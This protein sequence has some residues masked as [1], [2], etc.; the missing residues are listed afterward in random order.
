VEGQDTL[1]P[2]DLDDEESPYLRRQKAV[3]VRRRRFSR[4]AR[5]VF[6]G[7]AALLLL[8]VVS[9]YLVSFALASSRFVLSSPD[10]VVV[11]GNQYV[12]RQEVLS[13]LGFS[14]KGPVRIG[15]SVFRLPLAER[16]KQVES[17][18]WVRSVSLS[19]AYPHRL[20]VQIV[21]RVPV[22][23]V[24]LGGRLKVVD[25]DGV[26]L[27]KPEKA[28]FD[29]PVVTGLEAAP[30]LAERKQRLALYLEFQTQVAAEA[31]HSGWLISE[32]NLADADDLKALMVHG[33]QTIQ[34]HFGDRD[35]LERF[36]SFLT[37]LPEV[38]KSNAKIDSVDLRY[39]NQIVVNPQSAGSSDGRPQ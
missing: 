28:D 7:I 22:A 13:A 1:L 36:R 4:H 32:V 5:W 2:G 25:G 18:P 19:R 15:V 11:E 12:S 27:E 39:D 16:R 20:A 26:F 31:G 30:G 3:A 34:L 33:S 8:G 29:F 38:Q 21:E 9:Y 23:F 14:A 37:L 35:F 24:N 10:D 17:I 6:L